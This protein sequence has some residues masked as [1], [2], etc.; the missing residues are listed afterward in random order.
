MWWALINSAHALSTALRKHWR[1]LLICFVDE[2]SEFR[3]T[4][5]SMKKREMSGQNTHTTHQPLTDRQGLIEHVCLFP[6]NISKP[7]REH[8]SF[9][10]PN[11]GVIYGLQPAM[12]PCHHIFWCYS[13]IELYLV[14]HNDLFFLHQLAFVRAGF[15]R[16]IRAAGHA[17]LCT[18]YFYRTGISIKVCVPCLRR[19]QLCHWFISR[20]GVDL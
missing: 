18:T 17:T 9:L 14:A 4:H 11:V 16:R 1:I 8:F 2:D 10:L 7:L 12:I 5:I 15:W 6:K 3:M 19:M 13:F 20:D